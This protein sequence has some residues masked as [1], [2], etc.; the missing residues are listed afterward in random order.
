M[1]NDP[2]DNYEELKAFALGQGMA[3]FGV[4][5]FEPEEAR[6]I[7]SDGEGNDLPF[8]ISMGV[9]LSRAILD[10][11]CDHPTLLYQWHYRQANY[12]LD[13]VAFQLS[14]LIQ[15][16][17]ARA[18]PIPAS[19]IVDWENQRAHLSH[20]HVA[21]LAGHGWI[22][23]NNLLVNPRF[24]SQVRYVTVLTDLPLKTDRPIE[25]DCGN[26]RACVDA[27]PV[28]ALG[29]TPEDYDFRKCFEKLKSFARERGIG[30]YICGICVRA[31]PGKGCTPPR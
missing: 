20:K 13:R 7:L 10:G 2:K 8:A 28:G 25:G 29:D 3:L 1:K 23:R 22:G 17:G 11:I 6:S 5:P 30:H 15:E 16:K 31:C 4:A 19:Q 27:C 12:L 18:V 26:C 9:R 24:G 21:R 14:L